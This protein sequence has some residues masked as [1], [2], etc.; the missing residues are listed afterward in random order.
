MN[1]LL[2]TIEDFMLLGSKPHTP[3]NQGEQVD[4]L[5]LAKRR[6]HR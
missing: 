4:R 6:R 1:R 5:D 3:V 2:Q